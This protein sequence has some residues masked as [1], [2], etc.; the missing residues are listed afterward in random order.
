MDDVALIHENI[1]EL[2]EMINITND[3]AMRYH[4]EFGTAKCKIIKIGKGPKAEIKLNN[5][6]LEEVNN[7]KYL[8]EMI[9]NKGNIKDHIEMIEGKVQA[10]TQTI[11]T[12]TGNKEFKGIKM[13]AIWLLVQSVIIPILTYGT[14]GW[15]TTKTEMEH[16]EKIF[17]RTIKTILALPT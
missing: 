1:T 11:I 16:I 3:I 15:K 7:Y 14:E 6:I 17:I 4:I 5:Q 12:E 10:A 9:N 2:Q 8:G 13:E